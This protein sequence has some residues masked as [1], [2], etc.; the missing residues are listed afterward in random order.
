MD[1]VHIDLVG[2]LPPSQG[3]QYLLTCIDRFTR[4]PEAIPIKDITAET[5]ARALISG[6]ISRFGVY[7]HWSRQSIRISPLVTASRHSQ[8]TSTTPPTSNG[9]G[10]TG[11]SRNVQPIPISAL[12]LVLLGIRAAVK[13]PL[14]RR[15]SNAL[16]SNALQ[17]R[18]FMVLPSDFPM[19]WGTLSYV[20]TLKV[21][22]LLRISC[23][24]YNININNH[25]RPPIDS[26][27]LISICALTQYVHSRLYLKWCCQTIASQT[28]ATPHISRPIQGSWTQN[29]TFRYCPSC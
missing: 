14:W 3:Y 17:Q 7:R 15:T 28:I 11:N 18:W 21:L 10:S 27:P 26:F 6:W 19:H 23:T 9:N 13:E 22:I 1:F 24:N 4:W 8:T 25:D 29:E 16:P 5:V 2:P 20:D 12:P